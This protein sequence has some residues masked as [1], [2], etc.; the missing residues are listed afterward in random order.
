MATSFRP[1]F[2]PLALLFALIFFVTSIPRAA[3][4]QAAPSA[5]TGPAQTSAASDSDTE[6]RQGDEAMIAL[7]Y[8]E[9]LSHYRRAYETTKSPALLYNMGRAYE[10]L[11]EFPKALDALEEFSEKAA[12]DL[13]ARVPK[14][15]E[16]IT[17]VRNRVSTLILG[18]AVQDAEI[19]LGN[20]V[21]GKTK[22]G[23]T[24]FRVNAGPQT[25][26]ISH[27]DYFPFE[28]ALLLPAG[29]I[30]TV[31][32]ALASRTQEALLRV[33][34]P[35]SGAAVVIDG[36]AIGN[37]PA[38]VPMKP[39]QHRIALSRDGYDR[40]ETSVVVVAGETKE[41][42][43]PMATHETITSKWWFWTGIGVV[44][45]AGGVATYIALTT[46]KSP[47]AGT[48]APGTVKAESWGI[49]F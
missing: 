36:K 26:T 39:G 27:P 16:L 14:L 23:Q 33:T 44:L 21:I 48:I 7:R 6:K 12:P 2:Q 37:V 24:V 20:R 10:G 28:R 5:P 35:V 18:A 25:L 4:A 9:A 29:K 1:V 17:D 3:W 19:R 38:E 30:E 34:S 49:R 42:S 11:A 47:T 46:E 45:V 40:A 8:E 31:D 15:A 41:V 13:K 22:P 32:I 43:V